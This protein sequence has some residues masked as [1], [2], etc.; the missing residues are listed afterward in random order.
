MIRKKNA[1]RPSVKIPPQEQ[2]AQAGRETS[3][4]HFPIVGIGAS[5]GG[6]EAFSELLKHIPPKTGLAF[7]I[8]QHLDPDR[9]SALPELL[10]RVTSIPVTE[11]TD[12][13]LVKPDH[14]Y[15]IPPKSVA[16][17][18]DGTLKLRPRSGSIAGH[19]T[20]DLFFE[21]LAEDSRERAIGVILSGTAS[22]GTKGLE[23]IKAEG[24]ITFAQDDSA[25][26][27]SMPKNAIAADCVDFV[28]SPSGIAG[29]LARIASHPYL[30]MAPATRARPPLTEP[31]VSDEPS[32]PAGSAEY[33]KILALLRTHSGV[34]F[35]LYKSSTILRRVAR[36]MVLHRVDGFEDYARILKSDKKEL[37]ALYA[38]V[39]I[40]VTEFFR[41]P[42]AFEALKKV[43]FPKLFSERRSD[44]VRIWVPGCSMGQEAYSLAMAYAEFADHL[45]RARKVQIFATDLNEP[46]L[47]K[48]RSGFYNTSLVAGVSP[49]R[50]RRFFVE[51][52]GGYRI[53]KSLRESIVFARQNILADPP[54]S[55]IDLISCRNVLIYFEQSLQR[56]VIP[57]FHYALKPKG[58]LLLGASESIGTFTDLFDTVDK[59]LKIYSK[60]P[61]L[62]PSLLGERLESPRAEAAERKKKRKS[63][64]V[65]HSE[66][67]EQREI[68]RV[69]LNIY[70]PPGVVVN[71]KSEVVQ[72]RG[73]T[74]A[75]LKAPSG[76]ASFD[77][78]KMA[79]DGMLLPLRSA[80]AEAKKYNRSV[81]KPGVKMNA[82]KD[83]TS[84]AIHVV[85]LKNLKDTLFLVFFERDDGPS[86]R[87]ESPAKSLPAD[88]S[89]RASR[90]IAVLENELSETR[91][92]LQAVEQQSEAANEGLQAS[93]EEITSANEE[94][95]SI[96]EELE[97]SK[98]ELE[99]TNE[100]LTTV[101][102]ELSNRNTELNQVNNDL[103]NLQASTQLPI[104][105][106]GL[107]LR[108]RWYSP[109]AEK[110]FNLM[111]A[112]IG[113]TVGG[114]RHNLS[115]P[116]FEEFVTSAIDNV[117]E[118]TREVQDKQGRWYSLRV[119]PYMT[120]DRK[121]DGAVLVLLDIDALKQSELAIS[122]AR[123]YTV[124]MVES[125]REP[126]LVLDADLRVERAN[127]SFYDMFS[128]SPETV[129]GRPIQNLGSG[130][131]N[132]P[133]LL[134][135]LQT[136][137]TKRVGFENFEVGTNVSGKG[138]RLFILNGR[139][140]IDPLTQAKRIVVIIEDATESRRRLETMHQARVANAVVRTV[141]DPL[142]ILGDNLT[143]DSANNAFYDYFKLTPEEAEG[144]SIFRV[145]DGFLDFP[146]LRELLSDIVPRNSYFDN[147]EVSHEFPGV[148]SRTMLLHA[149]KLT[150]LDDTTG[151]ILLGIQDITELLHYQSEMLRSEVRYRRL[152]ETAK[153]GI[154]ILDADS[155]RVLDVNPC[156]TDLLGY[157]REELVGRN[158]FDIG[159]LLYENPSRSAF[160]QMGKNSILRYDDLQIRTKPGE[161]RNVE[162]VGTLYEERGHGVIQCNIRDIT[163]RKQ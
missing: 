103:I 33:R 49:G 29:E 112:D 138:S 156:L 40:S 86:S 155:T 144:K 48:A 1:K 27:P 152:F 125:M 54:F 106:L 38:D 89:V 65:F 83:S 9:E 107:D 91:D 153:D 35:S 161:I 71:S 148:G 87:K 61:R 130:E 77:L 2:S 98:E 6:L 95:Q 134:R 110:Q 47:D 96:N 114:I 8:I 100:E 22:D 31:A 128:Y 88:S 124:N 121:V 85:P 11:I 145:G 51:E 133:A 59:K 82:G 92:Y 7:V 163:G 13:L 37:E 46:L 16:E 81:R 111:A 137:L 84:F 4:S 146:R 132:I 69:T 36:R 17:I 23:A 108:I 93:N 90:R 150:G 158:L 142:V 73:D 63:G 30:A 64:I 126:L 120:S 60:N 102:E 113:R 78:L 5:A 154:L 72:F 62:S 18:E 99:S 105:L 50:L 57:F 45:P 14:V 39:L 42:T 26:Y 58:F 159:F 74:S 131:W 34:D 56:R 70:S 41:N 117:S 68:D 55:R 97:T 157:P 32:L 149:R 129:Q 28:L 136:V 44:P 139:P 24:G 25:K 76:K 101:N 143:V 147:L 53:S 115:I 52:E 67:N 66:I 116:D 20:I 19:R 43:I 15:V 135:Q 79:R 140:M 141:R 127:K 3:M 12:R 118:Q 21:S 80:L 94:L 119:R 123:D 160:E 162:L 75:F 10:S 104:L 122:A 151:R 109:Q